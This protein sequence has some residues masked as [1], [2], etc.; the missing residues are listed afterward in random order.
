MKSMTLPALFAWGAACFVL[1]AMIGP[2]RAEPVSEAQIK[3]G[4]YLVE[5]VAM[6]ANCHTARDW[7]GGLD[8]EHWL[9]GS[10]LDFK[11]TRLMPWAAVAPAIAGL[12]T[13]AT[14]EQAVKYFESGI[15]GAGNKSSPP[16]PQ[17]RFDHDDAVAVVAYLCSLKPPEK[18]G[19]Q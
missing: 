5:R 8:R 7:K 14:A 11:P 18:T 4:Q 19:G 12:P 15:N 9:Q 3:R 10:K 17:S 1:A 6:C 13:F 16:M 2:A